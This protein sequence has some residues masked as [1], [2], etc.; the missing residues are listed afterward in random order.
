MKVDYI[1]VNARLLQGMM[2]FVEAKLPQENP[3]Y[4]AGIR[5]EANVLQGVNL[6]YVGPDVTVVAHDR[7]G[8]LGENQPIFIMRG[9]KAQDENLTAFLN[10]AASH[11][12]NQIK[13][14]PKNFAM[15]LHYA[16]DAVPVEQDRIVHK[17]SIRDFANYPH[18]WKEFS[19]FLPQSQVSA[20]FSVNATA[21][22]KF[23]KLSQRIDMGHTM[24]A[25]EGR[26]EAVLMV[27]RSEIEAVMAM[28]LVKAEIHTKGYKQFVPLNGDSLPLSRDLKEIERMKRRT[29]YTTGLLYQLDHQQLTARSPSHV[30]GHRQSPKAALASCFL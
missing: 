26:R 19:E 8:A 28:H 14:N 22:T 30:H 25:L 4:A 16:D 6:I 13:L 17:K 1:R 5:I 2:A 27:A 18:W 9:D 10:G 15:R 3:G 12:E 29:G 23:Q 21:V 24:V 20:E 11:K 7:E